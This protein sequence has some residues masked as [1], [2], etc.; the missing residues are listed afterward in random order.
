M[1]TVERFYGPDLATL[2]PGLLCAAVGMGAGCGLRRLK[3]RRRGGK[4]QS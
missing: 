3:N 2:L 1:L 4:A